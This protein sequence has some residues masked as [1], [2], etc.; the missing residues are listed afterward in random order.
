MR[1]LPLTAPIALGLLAPLTLGFS[2]SQEDEKKQEPEVWTIEDLENTADQI[3]REIEELRGKKFKEEVAVRLADQETFIEYVKLRADDEEELLAQ[4]MTAKLLGMVPGEIDLL[5]MTM[6]FLEEQVGGFYDPT[7]KTFYIMESFTGGVARVIMAHELTHALDDQYHDLDGTMKSFEGNTDAAL[8]HHAIVEGSGMALMALWVQKN[9]GSLSMKEIMQAQASMGSDAVEAAPPFVWKPLMAVYLRGE[10]FLRRT[11]VWSLIASAVRMDDI[12]Q[13]FLEPPRS[14]E[15]I[16][17]PVKYWKDERRDEPRVLESDTSEL[18][19][20]WRVVTEDTLG[21]LYLGI[22]TMPHEE[23]GGMDS[24]SL[25]DMVTMPFTTDAAEGW[26][27]DRYLLLE[28]D[29]AYVL[30]LATC[31]DSEE[32]ATEFHVAVQGLREGILEAM[33]GMKSAQGDAPRGIRAVKGEGDG[34]EILAWF[35]VDEEQAA[36]VAASVELAEE[37][38]EEDTEEEPPR[39]VPGG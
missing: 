8:A 34:V 20:D 12:E 17:H 1:R 35:G 23:R 21:E 16:L 14:T 30:R 25:M 22:F 39:I 31:W 6:S 5:A 10:S 26:G 32:D 11:N 15:Q 18:L 27:G 24:E 3:K 38:T 7:E 19:E 2:S 4:E 36:A 9:L 28:K 37:E 33:S 29:G 13:A